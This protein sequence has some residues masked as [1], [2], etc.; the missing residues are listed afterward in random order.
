VTLLMEVVRVLGVVFAVESDRKHTSLHAAAKA[1][2]LRAS[3][4]WTRSLDERQSL[5]RAITLVDRR[6]PN[7]PNC[8]RRALVEMS[9]DAGSSRELLLAGFK[10]GG[11]AG[12]GHAWLESQSVAER[13]DAVIP[14]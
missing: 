2:R 4:R 5:R 6:M 9:L 8:L 7:G 12:T 10:A 3:G 13:Y 1:A 14:I 11:S